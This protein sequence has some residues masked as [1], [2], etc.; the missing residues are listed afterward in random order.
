M[1]RKTVLISLLAFLSLLSGYLFSKVSWVGGIGI[2]LFYKHYNFF[3][4]WWKGGLL[5]FG[6]LLILTGI[7]ALFQ[8]APR[9][10]G[11][12]AHIT[13][14]L[15]S[16]SGLYF[17]YLDFQTTISHRWLGERFHLGAYCFWMGWLIVSIFFLSEKDKKQTENS[18]P[19]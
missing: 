2:S 3:K 8:L 12:A 1:K 11:L 10:T 16:L 15:V 7:H 9:K 6:I 13:G 17:T 14:L 5:M 19:G 4:T 18:N